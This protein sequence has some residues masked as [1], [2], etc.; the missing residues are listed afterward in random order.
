MSGGWREAVSKTAGTLQRLGVI[1]YRRGEITVLDR[2]QLEKLSCEWYAVVKKETDRV[3]PY[4]RS[5]LARHKIFCR[6]KRHRERLLRADGKVEPF[7]FAGLRA[8]WRDKTIP[9]AEPLE[10]F[11]ILTRD[12][13]PALGEVHDRMPVVLPQ[14]AYGAWLDRSTTS[15]QEA[16]ELVAAAVIEGFHYYPVSTRV[17]TPKNDDATCVT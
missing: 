6:D 3:L 13:T 5:C 17:N 11:T 12:P 15:S 9:D 4:L 14:S 2:P 7:F 8:S 1:E 16:G 10:T